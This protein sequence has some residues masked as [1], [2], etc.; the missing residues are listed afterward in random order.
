MLIKITSVAILMLVLYQAGC[1][2]S[3]NKGNATAE[4]P[5]AGQQAPAD[6]D[7]DKKSSKPAWDGGYRY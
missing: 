5:A 3:D 7:Q 1:A 4:T 6:S 2:S